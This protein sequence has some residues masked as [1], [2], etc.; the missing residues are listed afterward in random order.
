MN[1]LGGWCGGGRGCCRVSRESLRAPWTSGRGGASRWVSE[2]P[3]SLAGNCPGPFFCPPGAR[4]GGGG[5]PPPGAL[6]APWRCTP[7]S[8]PSGSGT[9]G[10]VQIFAFWKFQG[11]DGSPMRENWL[12][13]P[14]EGTA[15]RENPPGWPLFCAQPNFS[16]APG[17]IIMIQHAPFPSSRMSYVAQQVPFPSSGMPHVAQQVLFPSS[18]M[19]HVVQQVSFPSS[20]MPHVVQQMPSRTTVLTHAVLLGRFLWSGSQPVDAHF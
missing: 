4:C 3:F 10:S 8:P 14:P 12:L 17:I 19:L 18:G 20:G 11:A 5:Q 1:G 9:K 16:A 2:G 6:S 7:L 15:Q 13:E